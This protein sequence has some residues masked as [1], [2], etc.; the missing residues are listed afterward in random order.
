MANP[1]VRPHLVFFPE[2][3]GDNLLSAHQGRRWLSDLDPALTSP[4]IRQSG[5]DF[6]IF[7]PA[8]LFDQTYCI[9]I[10]WFRRGKEYFAMAW[11]IHPVQ[12]QSGLGW[13]VH[14]YEEFEIAACVLTVSFTYFI[15]SFQR[16]GVPD[17]RIML[18]EPL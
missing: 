8:V 13:V 7:E 5:Q 1:K 6:Y 2:D 12:H 17:P 3:S 4:M 9:P 14:E 10:R 16:R 11:R 15:A 18:G